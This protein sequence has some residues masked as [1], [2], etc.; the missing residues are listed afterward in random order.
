MFV[1]HEQRVNRFLRT[2]LFGFTGQGGR[3][4]SDQCA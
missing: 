4:S 2:R 1:V 3:E